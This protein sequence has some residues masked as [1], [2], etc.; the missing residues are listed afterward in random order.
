MTGF[1]NPTR[2]FGSAR[3]PL[4]FGRHGAVLLALRLLESFLISNFLSGFCVSVI[5]CGASLLV[6][7][8]APRIVIRWLL[9][10][11]VR[12]ERNDGVT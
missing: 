1:R 6:P 9:D 10:L 7:I 5:V 11:R 2:G 4:G 3:L 12:H 8:L